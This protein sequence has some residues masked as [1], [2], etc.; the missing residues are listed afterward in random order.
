[1]CIRVGLDVFPANFPPKSFPFMLM[2]QHSN[3]AFEAEKSIENLRN[4]Q[5]QLFSHPF[6]TGQYFFLRSTS[7]ILSCIITWT[8][9]SE[10]PQQRVQ[11]F[12]Y[13]A[14]LEVS[15]IVETSNFDDDRE[16]HGKTGRLSPGTFLP[17]LFRS[18]FFLRS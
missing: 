13:S 10:D 14:A 16:L 11:S 6:L 2:Y 7:P 18:R 8:F 9:P 3:W 15:I 12:L 17:I 4:S 1:M 5:L